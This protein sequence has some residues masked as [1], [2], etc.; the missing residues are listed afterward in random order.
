MML[1]YERVIDPMLRDLRLYLPQFGNLK[2]GQKVIDVCCGT[3]A[4]AVEYA[5]LGMRATG[6]DADPEMIRRAV[7]QKWTAGFS[8]IDFRIADATALPYGNG[9]FD[10]ASVCLALHENKAA[11]R[12]KIVS[13]M[14]RVVK[15]G[16]T[17]LFADFRAP[18][19]GNSYSSF[20]AMIEFIAGWSHYTN[21]RDFIRDG[22]LNPVLKLNNLSPEKVAYFKKDNFMLVMTK[23]I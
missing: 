7:R 17:L 10:A 21:S 16:G 8:E 5:R 3:G 15:R 1:D 12:F 23:N 11:V 9:A 6:V 20:I 19:P 2:A 18:A 14:R 4:Q 13:E 22:G